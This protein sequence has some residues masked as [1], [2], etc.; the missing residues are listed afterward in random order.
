MAGL[1]SRNSPDLA[2]G[3]GRSRAKHARDSLAVMLMRLDP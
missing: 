1:Y 3:G 2:R